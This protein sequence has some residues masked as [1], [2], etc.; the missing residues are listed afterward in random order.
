[1]F[2]SLDDLEIALDKVAGSECVVDV[3]RLQTLLERHQHIWL[4]QV[5]AA[6]VR[7]DW[8][9]EGFLSAAAAADA[10]HERRNLYLSPTLNGMLKL[11]GQLAGDA[12]EIVDSTLQCAMELAWNAGDTRTRA[13][14]RIDALVDICRLAA[15]HLPTGP[16]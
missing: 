14:R 4:Q 11:D 3:V 8:E 13:Q 6:E 7:G 10:R 12:G 1:M 5:R 2:D 15:A 9:A 16:G